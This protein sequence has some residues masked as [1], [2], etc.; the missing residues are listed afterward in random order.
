[1]NG[2]E[3]VPSSLNAR[4]PLTNHARARMSARRLSEAAIAA[5]MRYGRLVRVRGAEIYAI[6]RR[7]VE[8]YRANGID[9]RMVAGVQ[10]VCAAD[11]G[12]IVTAYRNHDF[13]KLRARGP[14]YR[15]R[16]AA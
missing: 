7:E 1:M 16:A 10:V 9:L 6:G 14:R 11:D 4:L 8:R 12:S 15:H 13:R 3:T 5:V 2:N